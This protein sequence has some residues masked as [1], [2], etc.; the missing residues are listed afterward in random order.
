M[1]DDERHRIAEFIGATLA[2]L[3]DIE[4]RLGVGEQA[5]NDIRRRLDSI[6]SWRWK[7]MGAIGVIVFLATLIAGKVA[8]KL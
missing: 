1:T 4:R 2:R 8:D 7:L 3:E 6:D 5:H